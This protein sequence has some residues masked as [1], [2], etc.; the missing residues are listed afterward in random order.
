MATDIAARGID[1]DMPSATWCNFELPNVPESYVHRI[2]RTARAGATGQAISLCAD[3]ERPL[4]KDIQK[5]TRQTIPT[6][7]RR[8]DRAL[9]TMAKAT[10]LAG[11]DKPE[12]VEAASG[13]RNR[14]R[15][16]PA[17]QQ[18]GNAAPGGG[19]PHARPR[20]GGG[21]GQGQ[22]RGP[23]QGRA[24]EGQGGQRQGGQRQGAPNAGGQS[25]GAQRQAGPAR[26]GETAPV[27]AS[28]PSWHPAD[29]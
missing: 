14:G 2:G 16:R 12:P 29:A 22:P 23:G 3:D 28:R 24:A 25:Q 11:G 20:N 8:K 4:L 18:A 10:R 6:E 15:G 9:A 13:D 1:V 27:R 21:S 17:H 19:R 5:L 7:D 26:G